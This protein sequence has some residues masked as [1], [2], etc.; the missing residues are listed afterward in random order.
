VPKDQYR[1]ES[2][3]RTPTIVQ[4]HGYRGEVSL[5]AQIFS[6]IFSVHGF[7]KET[8]RLSCRYM[9]RRN[10]DENHRY[11]YRS[12][13]GELSLESHPGVH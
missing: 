10:W 7:S 12:S 9:S 1:L 3:G 6:V 8:M 5:R 4:Y 2:E 13:C 11:P